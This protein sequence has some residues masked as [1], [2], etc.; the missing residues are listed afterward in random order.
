MAKK[1]AAEE[2]AKKESANWEDIAADLADTDIPALAKEYRDIL[3]TDAKN[4]ARK[5]EI[6]PELEIAVLTGGKEALSI[7]IVGL[8]VTR[9]EAQGQQ[10]VDPARIVE[11]GTSFGL[12]AEQITELLEYAT[13]RRP[14]YSYPLVTR[15]D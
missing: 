7:S 8:R 6:S 3:D 9:V 13:R 2:Y 14:S 1:R 5:E 10:Y 11:K 4:K 15:E 12:T